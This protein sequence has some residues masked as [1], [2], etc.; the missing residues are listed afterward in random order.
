M[1]DLDGDD[2]KID[3]DATGSEIVDIGAD[4]FNPFGGPCEGDF[5]GDAV[6]TAPICRPLQA[7]LVLPPAM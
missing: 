3:I 4:E 7:P 5:D 6:W 2:R 1:E